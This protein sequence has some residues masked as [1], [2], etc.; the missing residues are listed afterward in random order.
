MSIGRNGLFKRCQVQN[1]DHLPILM[2]L[3]FCSIIQEECRKRYQ[4][5]LWNLIS[6]PPIF[7]TSPYI[8]ILPSHLIIFEVKHSS[9]HSDVKYQ[10]I[11][12]T[13]FSLHTYRS[14]T[15][16]SCFLYSAVRIPERAIFQQFQLILFHFRSCL[17]KSGIISYVGPPIVKEIYLMSIKVSARE[18]T[19]T[20]FSLVCFS[21]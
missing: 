9:S 14:T 4:D 1:L 2:F 5:M 15:I 10:A 19:K 6:V 13:N 8:T 7:L 11:I 16:S 18:H 21:L 20:T 12:N 3:Q 17:D